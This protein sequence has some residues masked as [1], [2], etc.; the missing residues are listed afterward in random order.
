MVF[1][2]NKF[3]N[4]QVP[5]DDVIFLGETK[6]PKKNI[7]VKV[8]A[9]PNNHSKKRKSCTSITENSNKKQKYEKENI[10]IE[11]KNDPHA[12]LNDKG[13]GVKRRRF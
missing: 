1:K 2:D 8:K 10:V 7:Q 3:P 4:F 5:N 9:G 11:E 12:I 6:K 13:K